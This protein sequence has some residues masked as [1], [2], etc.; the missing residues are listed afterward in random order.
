MKKTTS[1]RLF[2]RN[3]ALATT[4]VALLSGTQ[5]SHALAPVKNPFEGYNP[6]ADSKTDLRTILSTEK[7]IEVTGK[8]YDSSGKNTVANAI[9]EVWHLSP[10]SKKYR[11][12]AK[13][14]T[15]EQGEYSFITEMPNREDA[16]MPRIYFKVTFNENSYFTELLIGTTGAHITGKHWEE[17]NLS[18]SKLLPQAKISKNKITINFNITN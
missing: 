6:Y 8:V 11:H 14:K 15:N 1:R 18:E 7:T 10:N 13:L 12:R 4:G 17:N 5:L 3:T 9:V 16:K 2:L